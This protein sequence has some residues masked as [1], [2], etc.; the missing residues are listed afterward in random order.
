MGTFHSS[1]LPRMFYGVDETSIAMQDRFIAFVDS[2]NPNDGVGVTEGYDTYWPT[3]Q[4]NNEL[5]EFG[6]NETGIL[7]DDFRA[8]SYE[9][10]RANLDVLTM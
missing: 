7:I 5:L 1:D 2:L 9:F 8:E 10:I 3:W 4:E 6:A